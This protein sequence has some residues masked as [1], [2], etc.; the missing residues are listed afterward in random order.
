MEHMMTEQT[1]QISE[2][3]AS[4]PMHCAYHPNREANLRCNR[5][6]NPICT[7][8]AVLTP[9]GYRCKECVK[10]QQKVFDT[11]KTTDYIVAGVIGFFLSLLGSWISSFLGFFVIF[12]APVAGVIIAEAIR[13]GVHRRRSKALFY[14]ATAAVVVGGLPFLLVAFLSWLGAASYYGRTLGIGGM[15]GFIWPIVYVF[16]AASTVY[17]RLRGIQIR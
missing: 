9:T 12:I 16:L 3:T 4:Q 8:C 13:W 5:C 6:D 10:T 17:Y 15:L 11:A 1:P 14:T 2:A 7:E